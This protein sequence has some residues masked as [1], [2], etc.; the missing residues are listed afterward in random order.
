MQPKKN[1]SSRASLSPFDRYF[2]Y[3]HS[4]Q[5]AEHDAE[6]LWKMM[7]KVHAHPLPKSPLLQEDFCGTAALCYEWVKLGTTHRAAGIDLDSDALDWGT[8][9]HTHGMKKAQLDRVEMI[10][11][12][13]LVDHGK[14]PDVICALN[15]SYFFIQ[16]R[17]TLKKYFSACRKTLAKNGVLILDS[18]GG[19]GYLMPHTDRRRNDEENFTY[20]WEIETFDAISNRIKCHIHFQRDGEA[21]R[22]RVFS[23]DWRLWS[24][25]EITDVLRECGFTHV[26]YWAEGLDANGHGDGIFKPTKSETEC[27]T[28]ITYI[29]AK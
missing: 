23:Y 25:P 7:R 14:K 21:K 24:I 10:H 3:T 11:D 22:N 8:Q 9:N 2:L 17:A 5:G 15:F 19:P 1:K 16:D 29:V 28:W 4:V 6:L 12:D 13:V 27:E 20:W 18:F 26:E